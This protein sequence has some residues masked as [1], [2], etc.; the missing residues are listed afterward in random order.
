MGDEGS[1]EWTPGNVHCSTKTPL[2][3]SPN[4]T[5][6]SVLIIYMQKF[7]HANWL[8]AV[9]FKCNHRNGGDWL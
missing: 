5:L 4:K 8:R 1:G 3:S 2:R 7:R 6:F 9:Q